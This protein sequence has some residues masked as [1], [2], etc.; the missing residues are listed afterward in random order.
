MLDDYPE[1][2][3]LAYSNRL[4]SMAR[5]AGPAL[6]RW[7]RASR[8]AARHP[9]PV[10][11]HPAV[12]RP[13]QR[14]CGRGAQGPAHQ[15]PA[16]MRGAQQR[17]YRGRSRRAVRPVDPLHRRVALGRGDPERIDVGELPGPHRDRGRRPPLQPSRTRTAECAVTVVEEDRGTDTR[18]CR[19]SVRSD[20][21]PSIDPV[22][23]TRSV[24]RATRSV[25]PD[26]NGR[27]GSDVPVEAD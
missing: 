14:G 5:V 22:G 13:G 16:P 7:Q 21:V 1:L 2:I 15:S 18:A 19:V 9:V 8:G 10:A 17:R 11:R 25:E 26:W 4:R 12:E 20:H 27:H 3:P 24:R 6:G 23:R